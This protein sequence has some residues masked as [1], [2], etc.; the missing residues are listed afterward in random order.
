MYT[1][2]WCLHHLY[3]R[4]KDQNA[5]C[6]CVQNYNCVSVHTTK[7]KMG[8]SSSRVATIF[9]FELCKFVSDH[10]FLFGGNVVLGG[11]ICSLLFICE[12]SLV[13]GLFARIQIGHPLLMWLYLQ[14]IVCHL[15]QPNKCCWDQKTTKNSNKSFHEWADFSVM[16]RAPNACPHTQHKVDGWES[17]ITTLAP[18]IRR[19]AQTTAAA[20]L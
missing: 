14:F 5:V 4:T 17:W 15:Q 7:I 10:S 6:V 16:P 12:G 11:C 8:S 18:P 19:P 2:R 9:S 1:L 3:S 13:D 20:T